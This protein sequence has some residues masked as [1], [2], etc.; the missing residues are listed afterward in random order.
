[1]YQLLADQIADEDPPEVW[2]TAR[3][4]LDGGLSPRFVRSNLFLALNSAFTGRVA[5]R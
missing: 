2:K 3:R 1:M 4:L 5:T